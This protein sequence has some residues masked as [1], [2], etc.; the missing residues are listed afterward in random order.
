MP[1]RARG[2]NII[3]L[4]RLIHW[5]KRDGYERVMIDGSDLMYWSSKSESEII[6]MA[7]VVGKSRPCFGG[8]ATCCVRVWTSLDLLSLRPA[9]LWRSSPNTMLLKLQERSRTY[10][11]APPKRTEAW[12][13]GLW[14]EVTVSDSLGLLR[15][16]RGST[17]CRS[18]NTSRQKDVG[19]NRS[20]F[21]TLASGHQSS[22]RN[23]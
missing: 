10:L 15:A 17:E 4:I 20:V 9:Q 2:P 6:G 12:Q 5:P 3:S 8:D 16:P 7:K 14:V 18:T 13:Y 21:E 19:F 1:T 22:L 23:G 11:K